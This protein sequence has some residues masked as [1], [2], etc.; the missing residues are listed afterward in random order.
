MPI[1]PHAPDTRPV[2]LRVNLPFAL[3]VA[4]VLPLLTALGFWQL[5]RAI[6]KEEALRLYDT[7]RTAP[8]AALA[9]LDPQDAAQ[10]DARRVVLKGRY[11]REKAFLLDNRIL[12]G[13]VGYELLM[14]FA[15]TSGLTVIVN[16]GWLQAPP[17]R[18]QLPEITTPSDSIEL[19]GEL[20]VPPA[21]A[22]SEPSAT[23][24]WPSVVQAVDVPALSALAGVRAFPYLVRLEPGQPGVTDADWPRVNMSPD[25]HRAYA[26]QWFLMAIA[27]LVVF[28]TG[29]TNIR[30]CLAARRE[31]STP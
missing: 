29:G 7:R 26:A 28:V 14:P 16:R 13:R 8:P 27:L 11:M 1:E 21:D 12:E 2:R 20:H 5:G 15:D 3:L 25:R 6:E 31:R 4:G 24:G 9:E 19:R 18:A 17:T 22:K 23:E 30:A 10:L